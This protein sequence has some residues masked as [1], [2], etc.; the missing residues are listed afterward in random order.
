MLPVLSH[1]FQKLIIVLDLILKV[2]SWYQ[3]QSSEFSSET[4][5]TFMNV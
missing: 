4:F 2:L 5:R 1:R 3:P